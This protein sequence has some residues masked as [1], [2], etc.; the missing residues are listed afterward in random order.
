MWP[1]AYFGQEHWIVSPELHF[2]EL[3]TTVEKVSTTTIQRRTAENESSIALANYRKKN[4]NDNANSFLNITLRV[5][6]VAPRV[7]EIPNFVSSAEVSHIMQLAQNV[8]FTDLR[9][10]YEVA[11]ERETSLVLDAIY[12]R[13]ADVL[14]VDEALMRNRQ[15]KERTDIAGHFPL[16]ETLRVMKFTQ[17]Q[18]YAE[19]VDF[20]SME[21][22]TQ[23]GQPNRFS[24]L[25]IY[26]QTPPQGGATTFPRFS[27]AH[28][29]KELDILPEAGSAVLLYNQLPD[30]NL[31][32]CALYGIKTVEEGEMIVAYLFL[33]DPFL[34][35]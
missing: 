4:E 1:A 17:G 15:P 21:R 10:R 9:T 32:D 18:S 13:A 23:P 35:E 22:M 16:T 30:G 28:T 25:M 26:L 8:G 29:A 19:H 2:Q 27:S 3:P 20:G 7:L 12:R 11:V 6:S 24:T 34:V 31:D 33:W 5:T 14:R